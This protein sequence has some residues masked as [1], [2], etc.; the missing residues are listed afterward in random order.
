MPGGIPGK[1]WGMIPIGI[2]IGRATALM[3]ALP[4]WFSIIFTAPV[5]S[6]A[7]VVA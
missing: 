6:S 1:P 4:W 7:I 2:A 3:N 5:E